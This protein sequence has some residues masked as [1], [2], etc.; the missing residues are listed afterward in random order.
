VPVF[1]YEAVDA[2]EKKSRGIVEAD[3]PREA[4]MKLMDRNLFLMNIKQVGEEKAKAQVSFW[5]RV[6]SRKK[7][8]ELS[9]VTR[10]FATLLKAGIPVADA[11]NALVEQVENPKLN[12]VFRDLR[13]KVNQGMTL[14]DALRAHPRYFDPFYVNMIRVGETSGNLDEV[15]S[16]LSVYLQKHNRTRA[17]VSAAMVYPVVML[18]IGILVATFLVTFV[19]PKITGVLSEAGR[20]LPTPTLILM[21]ISGFIVSYWWLVILIA[22]GLLMAYRGIAKTTGGRSAIDKIWLKLPLFGELIRK[23]LIA[24]FSRAFAT[25]IRSGVPALEALTVIRVIMEN[26]VLTEAVDYIHDSV[27]EGA[28]IAAPLRKS[29][30]FPP[31]VGYMIAT[32]E[33]SGRL[34]EMLEM[35]ADYY[36]EEVDLATQKVTSALEPMLIVF[37]AVVVGF[38]VLAVVLPILELGNIA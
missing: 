22:L 38:I 18:V 28:D 19:V 26:S 17:K 23:N 7:V 36:D 8:S 21:G 37:L 29:G 13:E 14:E 4:R 33:E 12:I 35:I 3:T 16:R 5:E 34:E 31:L 1:H 27:I 20:V 15:L 9:L 2:Q 32:G 24:R 10:Q 30:V 25:L 11:L 6:L